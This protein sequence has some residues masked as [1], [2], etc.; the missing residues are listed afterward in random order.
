MK[1]LEVIVRKIMEEREIVNTENAE[2]KVAENCIL[3]KKPGSEQIVITMVLIVIALVIAFLYKDQITTFM[4][5]AITNLTTKMG[6]LFTGL[7]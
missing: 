6:E 4:T 2:T 3:K 7:S 1:K 5:T